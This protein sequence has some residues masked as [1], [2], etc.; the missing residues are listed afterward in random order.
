V[1]EAF[2]ERAAPS[3][4]SS[5]HQTPHRTRPPGNAGDTLQKLPSQS[6]P[7]IAE[8]LNPHGG[9][10]GRCRLFAGRNGTRRAR[11]LPTAVIVATVPEA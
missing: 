1:V 10:L 8:R 6:L 4:D 5:R 2:A 11:S 9:S 7:V 3:L